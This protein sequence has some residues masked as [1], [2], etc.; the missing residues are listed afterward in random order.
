M[1]YER[2]HTRLLEDYGGL[3]TVMPIFATLLTIVCFSSIGVPGTNG[4]IGEFLV[5]VGSYRTQPIFTVIAATVVIFSAAYLLWALQRII[6]NP[7]TKPENKSL[8]DLNWREIGLLVPLIFVIFWMGV[9]PKPVLEKTQAAASR[10][11]RQ[12]ETSGAM[13]ESV[14]ATGS[15]R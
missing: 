15:A 4:F 3:A 8:L 9:Y 11:I 5:L 2:R 10:L 1:M 13:A 7:L 6:Y 14:P 12:V